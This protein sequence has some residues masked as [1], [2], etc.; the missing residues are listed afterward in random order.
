MA[1]LRPLVIIDG[2]IQQLPSGDTIDGEALTIDLTEADLTGAAKFTPVYI[3]SSSS[4]RQSIANDAVKKDVVGFTTAAV[5]IGGVG[6]IQLEGVLEGTTGDWDTVT[7]GTGGLVA[8][9]VYWLDPDNLGRITN[10][11]PTTDGDYV[12]PLGEAVSTTEFIIDID[13]SVLL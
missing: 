2:Q 7:G 12:V 13:T 4:F 9:D 1:L 10:T 8:G 11:A 3:A 5:T 6:T